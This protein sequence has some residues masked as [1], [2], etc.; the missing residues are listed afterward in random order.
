MVLVPSKGEMFVAFQSTDHFHVDRLSMKG[1]HDHHHVIED[2]LSERG[3]VTFAIDEDSEMLYWADGHRNIIEFSDFNGNNRQKFTFTQAV[4]QMALIKDELFWTSMN[5]TSLQ[6]RNKTGGGGFKIVPIE[7]PQNEKIKP[8]FINIAAGVPLKVKTHLCMK[9]NGGCSDICVSD[10]PHSR[11]CLCRTGYFFQNNKNTS[12]VARSQCGFRCSTSGECLELSHRCDDK[13][14]C[15]DGSDEKNC[16]DKS[17]LKCD[18]SQFMCKDGRQCIP[19]SQRCDSHYNCDDMSDEDEC[20]T[21]LKDNRCRDNQ[22][23]CQSGFCLDVTQR[24]DGHDDC[25]DG[26]DEREELCEKVDC[27]K[28]FFKC[29]SGQCVPSSAVCNSKIDCADSSDEHADC[30]ELLDL[31][32]SRPE[33]KFSQFVVSEKKTCK[34]PMK[35]CRNGWCLDVKFFCDGHI[36]C[37]DGFD[38]IDCNVKTNTTTCDDGDFL[39][40]SNGKCIDSKLVC[41]QNPECPKGEDEKDCPN[42]AL[43]MFECSSGKCIPK[44]FVCDGEKDCHDGSDELKCGNESSVRSKT[45]EPSDFT[46]SNGACLK[47]EKVCDGSPD[48]SDDEGGMCS[49]ACENKPCDQKCQK[50]PNGAKCSCNKGFKLRS[51]ADKTCVDINECETMNPCSQ[52]CRN[53]NGSFICSCHDGFML[54]SDKTTCNAN[55]E[56]HMILF[57]FYDQIRR[58]EIAARSVDIMVT[59]KVAAIRD[60][61]VNLKEQKLWFS[62]VHKRELI[63]VDMKSGKE[64]AISGFPMAEQIRHDWISGN[65]YIYHYTEDFNSEIHICRVETKDCAKIIQLQ[66]PEDVPAMQVDPINKC[67]FFVN[68]IENDF[69]PSRSSIVKTRLDGSDLK[70]IAN[71]T[72]ITTMAIDIDQKRVYFT[73]W[74]TQSLNVIDYKGE[75]RKVLVSMSPTLKHP[76]SMS[77]FESHA[78]ILLQASSSMTRC[79]LY[80]DFECTQVDIMVNNA[81]RILITQQS[82]QKIIESQCSKSPCEDICISADAGIKCLCANGTFVSQD[83]SCGGKKGDENDKVREKKVGK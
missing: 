34:P 76:L 9:D 14:D 74:D 22:M 32:F 17:K 79:K 8:N 72:R 54:A 33:P 55:G 27:P 30:G 53:T 36:D 19:V 25:G 6:W 71:D 69:L 35:P 2:G 3:P 20:T 68:L 75:N 80:G 29:T 39:C 15:L 83:A 63:E 60:F 58:I 1:G 56:S 12:C 50:T 44:A 57:S 47:Y 16:E 65:H 52:D 66:Y 4:G 49:S 7:L 41:N 51:A 48:C 26:W 61:D 70:I 21:T 82:K 43:N 77:L 78:Y 67:F 42:C 18:V 38:E 81:R 13:L 62:S 11:N 45:C 24:C 46:C 64:N 59:S 5:S 10:G 73:E 28:D 40:I 31:N 37:E 23:Q